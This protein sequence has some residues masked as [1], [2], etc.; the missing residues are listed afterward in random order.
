MKID[1]ASSKIRFRLYLGAWAIALLLTGVLVFCVD[2]DSTNPVALPF[3]IPFFPFGMMWLSTPLSVLGYPLL[4]YLFYIAHAFIT[5]KYCRNTGFV[6][7]Y[8]IL[9]IVLVTNVYG[10]AW[11]MAGSIY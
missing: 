8:I 2:K 4:G 9:V 5:L 3:L 1:L 6:V 7:M 11:T 10:C